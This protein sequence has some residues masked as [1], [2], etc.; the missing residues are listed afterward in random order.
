MKTSICVRL[1]GRQSPDFDTKCLLKW[2]SNI[3]EV[4]E[5][6][7]DTL[8][9]TGRSDLDNWGYSDN[10]LK[11]MTPPNKEANFTLYILN[12]PIQDDFFSRRI[13]ENVVC[14]SFWEIAEP[15]RTHNIPIVCAVLRMIYAYTL[16]HARRGSLPPM[17]E[18][19]AFA[20]HE[21]KGC[22]FDMAGLPTNIVVSCDKPI[23]CESCRVAAS[24]DHVAK[25]TLDTYAKE[26]GRIRKQLYF[27][28]TDWVKRHPVLALTISL[29][30]A[31]VIGTGG[32]LIA[33]CIYA[34]CTGK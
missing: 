8:P 21:N 26:I 25:E 28:M 14:V 10:A 5:G 13:S 29:I 15:L 2:K 22:I 31:L 18:I 6:R 16:V 9:L 19:T 3:W 33:S 30:T 7:I 23:L 27:R 34:T 32:S 24:E 17:T 4:F 11:S 1:L 20:H 12:A